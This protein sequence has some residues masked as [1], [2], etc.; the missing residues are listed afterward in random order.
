MTKHEESLIRCFSE[1]LMWTVL[2]PSVL[3]EILAKQQ[4]NF[5]SYIFSSS[6]TSFSSLVPTPLVFLLLSSPL[7]SS[8]PFSH[9]F[10]LPT[11]PSPRLY[12][13]PIPHHPPSLLPSLHSFLSGSL[14]KLPLSHHLFI[15]FHKAGPTDPTRRHLDP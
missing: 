12:P 9:L 6:I 3:L 13:A 2:P 15:T 11:S 5:Y 1:V 14:S 4:G 8:T 10:L 7:S